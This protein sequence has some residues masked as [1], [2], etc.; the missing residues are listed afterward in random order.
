MDDQTDDEHPTI[1]AATQFFT[2]PVTLHDRF[3]YIYL[4]CKQRRPRKEIRKLLKSCS[5]NT[6]RVLD[7]TFPTE[8]VVGILLHSQYIPEASQCF[9]KAGINILTTFDP[10]N[11]N[12]VIDTRYS[13]LSLPEKTKLAYELHQN[14]CIQAMQH[15]IYKYLGQIAGTFLSKNWITKDDYDSFDYN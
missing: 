2:E 13:T 12:N 7:I 4:P 10:L 11:P 15:C 8:K 3:D 1:S 14:R 6:S 9:R 5:I